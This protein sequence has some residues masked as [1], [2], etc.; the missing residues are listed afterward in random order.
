MA[1]IQRVGGGL[2]G[3]L[4]G[5]MYLTI[6]ILRAPDK[7]SSVHQFVPVI[8]KLRWSGCGFTTV[9]T[10]RYGVRPRCPDNTMYART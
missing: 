2:L 1:G 7:F 3:V 4:S 8:S 6:D 5:G 10:V 9:R